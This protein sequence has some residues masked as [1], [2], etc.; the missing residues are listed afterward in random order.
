[1]RRMSRHIE[2]NY[3]LLLVVQLEFGR[4]VAFVAVKDKEPVGALR[5]TFYM[6]IKVFYLF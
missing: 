1:M 3:V 2:R 5:T 4:I 6:E